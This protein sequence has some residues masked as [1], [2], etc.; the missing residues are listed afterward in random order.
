[1][2]NIFGW[3]VHMLETFLRPGLRANDI[4]AGDRLRVVAY[5]ALRPIADPT[6]VKTLTYSE[7]FN[8]GTEECFCRRVFL[9][10]KLIS[11]KT[12]GLKETL[13]CHKHMKR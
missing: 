3:L 1:M 13:W 12:I 2:T 11:T 5:E 7:R 4:V 8:A 6:E 9:G 10:S